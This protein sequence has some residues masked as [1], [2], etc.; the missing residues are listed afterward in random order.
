MPSSQLQTGAKVRVLSDVARVEKLCAQLGTWSRSKA[1]RCGTEAEVVDVDRNDDSYKLKF[2]D[3][4][5][6]WFVGSA[7]SRVGAGT[8]SNDSEN[9]WEDV[10]RVSPPPPP[11]P[12]DSTRISPALGNR[13][14][15]AHFAAEP[16]A[17]RP[18]PPRQSEADNF[19]EE[20]SSA[21]TTRHQPLPAASPPLPSAAK[22]PPQPLQGHP[23]SRAASPARLPSASPLLTDAEVDRMFS[24]PAGSPGDAAGGENIRS[25]G[26]S[27]EGYHRSSDQQTP[28]SS[29]I[30]RT[31]SNPALARPESACAGDDPFL[32]TPLQANPAAESR[33]PAAC[34]APAHL[35]PTHRAAQQH[36][37][38]VDDPFCETTPAR[39]D[40]SAQPYSSEP[41]VDA[42]A[43]A[44]DF[45]QPF[46]Q[47]DDPFCET[48]QAPFDTTPPPVDSSAQPYSSEPAVDAAA[49][50]PDFQQPSEQV[51]DPFC[52]TAQAPFD[53][54]PPP[55]VSSAQ[56]YPSE[57]EQSAVDAAASDFQ[58]PCEQ[59]DDPFC[60]TA[61]AP[62]DTTPPPV[63]S[64]AQPH[65][66]EPVQAAGAA[67]GSARVSDAVFSDPFLPRL[68]TTHHTANP[69]ADPQAAPFDS[70]CEEPN[71]YNSPIPGG[72]PAE[73]WGLQAPDTAHP[74]DRELGPLA[75]H[76]DASCQQAG[77]PHDSSLAAG[78]EHPA[79]VDPAHQGQELEAPAD[80]PADASLQQDGFSHD[81]G[82]P[83]DASDQQ[84]YNLGDHPANASLQQDGLSHDFGGPGDASDQQKYN[85]GVHAAE[86][87]QDESSPGEPDV[88][89]AEPAQGVADSLQASVPQQDGSPSDEFPV[90]PGEHEPRT[91]ES[92]A[93]QPQVGDAGAEAQQYE[94]YTD[95]QYTYCYDHGRSLWVAYLWDEA[96]GQWAQYDCAPAED[97]AAVS[98]PQTG[99]GSAEQATGREEEETGQAF[100]APVDPAEDPL[101]GHPEAG[102]GGEGHAPAAEGE[103]QTDTSTLPEGNGASVGDHAE[104]A[105]PPEGAPGST[106]PAANSDA[107]HP[108][109]EDGTGHGPAAVGVHSSE[110][111]APADQPAGPGADFANPETAGQAAMG[112][113][114]SEHGIPTDQ[115]AGPGPDFAKPETA[116]QVPMAVHSSEHEFPA[117]QPAE[118][119]PDFANPEAADGGD[120]H[121]APA[122]APDG[123]H[124]NFTSGAASPDIDP[125]TGEAILGSEAPAPFPAA[126]VARA[127]AAQPPRAA[128][129]GP[130]EPPA[131]G[132]GGGGGGDPWQPEPARP[133]EQL[134]TPTESESESP[135]AQA[136]EPPAEQAQFVSPTDTLAASQ[137]PAQ[138]HYSDD[139]QPEAAAHNPAPES[140]PQDPGAGSVDD[141]SA[142]AMPET[143]EMAESQL[144]QELA[145][146]DSGYPYYYNATTGESRWEPPACWAAA[147][148]QYTE[149][150]ASQDN[151]AEPGP[152][153]PTAPD[154]TLGASGDGQGFSPDGTA[155]GPDAAAPA[156][157]HAGATLPPPVEQAADPTRSTGPPE[158]EGMHPGSHAAQGGGGGLQAAPMP[159][160]GASPCVAFTAGRFYVTRSQRASRPM[161]ETHSLEDALQETELGRH[162]VALLK[163]HPGP[164]AHAKVDAIV[165]HL[166]RLRHPPQP[167]QIIL[168]TFLESGASWETDHWTPYIDAIVE[169]LGGN[170]SSV[171]D[172]R[173][174]PADEAAPP[175]SSSDPSHPD[176]AAAQPYLPQAPG[177]GLAAAALPPGAVGPAQR[178]AGFQPRGDAVAPEDVDDVL[179]TTEERLHRA[180]RREE[181]RAARARDVA[182]SVQAQIL[183]GSPHTAFTTALHGGELC[184]GA[185][186]A[187]SLTEQTWAD[188]QL[189]FARTLNP[190]SP[191][192]HSL[193]VSQQ[194][195][196]VVAM[197]DLLGGKM[198]PAVREHWKGI[199]LA[200]LRTP[201]GGFTVETV[202]SLVE[203]LYQAQ[204]IEAAH[205]AQLCMAARPSKPPQN[206]Y[207]LLVGGVNQRPVCRTAFISPASIFQ[208][209][210]L[211]H[212]LQKQTKQAVVFEH[213]FYYKIALAF[214]LFEF[215]YLQA[216]LSYLPDP[217]KLKAGS[218]P[219][220]CRHVIGT[221][222]E[223]CSAMLQANKSSGGGGWGLTKLFGSSTKESGG[224]KGGAAAA[225]GKAKAERADA[226]A[227][228]ARSPSPSALA[229][230]DGQKPAAKKAKKS[231]WT[232]WRA[233]EDEIPQ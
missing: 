118:P 151:P 167:L 20:S 49:A 52:E 233:E 48:A 163:H 170:V 209:E 148:Q 190:V 223:R 112:V 1:K 33:T 86:L 105:P 99:G 153:H 83:G 227:D 77:A 70:L 188:V 16:A 216:C 44:P 5:C 27:P 196:P 94:T 111:E 47:V 149:W 226:D 132:G 106:G 56:P 186:L 115:L 206:F 39:V 134:F 145:D 174:V 168:K 219:P 89:P 182:R 58:Q 19:W 75:D 82:G 36:A 127:A 185:I 177:H 62:F 110:H 155:D 108:S 114:S 26:G 18:A 197:A 81:F 71:E 159:S 201:V 30:K 54:T 169:S 224:K 228:G 193:L 12:R 15:A 121:G 191:L 87:Q 102:A 142:Q 84:K 225:G 210:A 14:K 171:A 10:G 202:K 203:K 85:L 11:E 199:L 150:L 117:D 109:A 35:A 91:D 133:S 72:H 211:E 42:A 144:W 41:A 96:T 101:A 213:L 181:K 43:A 143:A 125:F 187:S 205:F 173:A 6:A 73:A 164:L 29:P 184:L 229:E 178:G 207:P 138:P 24:S 7:L 88:Y 189:A 37:E 38:R 214:Y 220:V 57:P 135:P 90:D 131:A 147:Q 176:P 8:G 217:K 208:T 116:G 124:P 120:E 55:V 222:H 129:E 204:D 64:G 157:K 123:R 119:G 63:D 60:E 172:P 100:E 79:V 179:C 146:P 141:G 221:L 13:I 50:A 78:V 103:V 17:A 122:F 59:V 3:D 161:L 74:Q 158:P 34:D 139:Q 215:G 23:D 25:E 180:L 98:D 68:G 92:Q 51:D 166:V 76:P 126:A 104:G 22:R 2:A 156:N 230:K 232:F 67:D 154:S 152:D 46:E 192:F 165:A 93:E 97:A 61:Q 195:N 194:M 231:I 137:E 218:V 162:E 140:C 53:T 113:H 200:L 28:N 136:P 31:P 95:G 212:H 130:S 69:P 160:R 107:E 21:A 65:H 198:E 183:H 66:P 9:G 4:R 80:H 128:P 40:S 32:S 175:A 45:Q